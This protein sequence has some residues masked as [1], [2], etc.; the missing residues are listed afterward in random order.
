MVMQKS[1]DELVSLI[2][3]LLLDIST[4]HSDSFPQKKARQTIKV[5]ERRTNYEGISFLTKTLPSLRKSLDQA[6]SEQAPLDCLRFRKIPG[7]QLPMF[8]GELFLLVFEKDGTVR[9]NPDVT[10]IRSLRQVLDL[11]YK[12]KLPYEVTL[13]QQVVDGFVEVD[14]ALP[15]P[16]SEVDPWPTHYQTSVIKEAKKLLTR[17]LCNFDPLNITPRHG[18]GAVATGEKAQDKMTFKRLYQTLDAVYPVTTY[19]YVGNSHVCDELHVLQKLKEVPS[20]EAKVSLVPKDSRGP[21]LISAEP[22]EIQWIQQGLMRALVGHIEGHPLTQGFVNFTD[23]TINRR[24]ALQASLTGELAT[25]DLK[26]ASDRVSLSLVRRLFPEHIISALEATRSTHTRLPCGKVIKLRKFAPMGS[27]LCFPV[28]A[29]TIWSLVRADAVLTR[30]AG[31]RTDPGLVYVFGDDVIVPSAKAAKTIEVLESFHLL[32]NR[33]K[34]FHTGFFRESCGVDAYKGI[35][36]QPVRLKTV[37][38]SF[39]DPSAYSAWLA[40][41]NQF[42]CLG[43]MGVAQHIAERLI[44]L[45][46]AIDR[47]EAYDSRKTCHGFCFDPLTGPDCKRRFNGRYQ[48]IERYVLT[49]KAKVT[50]SREL[51]WS[52][53]LR[54]LLLGGEEFRAGVYAVKGASCLVRRWR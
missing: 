27:G 41:A 33:A 1:Q 5:I 10:A 28:L 52:E 26:E 3:S 53:L 23:Q 2:A 50:R 21:R 4:I 47:I 6:L 17:L 25:L 30:R 48:R 9:M 49:V 11:F 37:W 7:T 36:V 18:P 19:F 31:D 35:E 15:D 24:L 45:Y 44:S 54:S 40:Y 39:R 29:L 12:Y 13:E 16:T 32:V 8:M 46:G 14:A 51:G 22:L 34:S 38:T 20:G 43:Y 42:Y